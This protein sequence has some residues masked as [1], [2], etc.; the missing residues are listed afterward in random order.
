MPAPISVWFLVALAPVSPAVRG[1]DPSPDAVKRVLKAQARRIE[2]IERIAPAVVCVFDSDRVGGGSGVLIDDE[3]YGLTNFHVVMPMM[4]TR[5]G[6]GGLS[7]GHLYSLEVLGV[8]VTGDV[9]MFRLTKRTDDDSPMRD[10]FPF[11]PLGDSGEVRVG[12]SVIAM[13]NPFVLAEDFKPTVTTGIVTGIHRY[14][15]EGENLVYTDCIQT[16]AAIN[17]GNSGGPLFDDRGRVIGINGRISAEMHRYA[18]GRYSVGLGYAISIDQI[19]RFMPTLRAGLLGKHGTLLATVMDEVDG[20]IFNDLYE[21]APAW[22]TGIRLGYRLLRFGDVDIMSANQF[23]SLL[24][25]Y[26]EDWP[27]PITFESRSRTA[28]KVVRLE[29]VT[30]R[31]A[32]RYTVNEEANRRAAEVAVRA[33]RRAILPHRSRRAPPSPA[34]PPKS[35]SWQ[36]ERKHEADPLI[37]FRVHDDADGGVR[38]IELDGDGQQVRVVEYRNVKSLL[39]RFDQRNVTERVEALAHAA[40]YVL[41][42]KLLGTEAVWE[43]DGFRHVGSDALLT[44][45]ENGHVVRERRLEAVSLP[46]TEHVSLKVGFEL[47]THLPARLVVRDEPS[48]LEVEIELDDYLETDGMVWP[49]RMQVRSAKLS[50]EETISELRVEF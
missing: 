31:M 26:P 42:R 16:D 22:N 44:I 2:V 13:G 41:R 45:D 49:R 35:W 28:H 46:L 25:T 4:R 50:F 34:A 1:A 14:Q 7:D 19:K 17:P 12:D 15:G 21:D 29:G 37:T 33:F 36:A 30:P 23:L 9:A 10:R 8:D 40:M 27:V 43:E 39:A 24:G 5:R 47:D 6:L 38:R 20:V 3:G 18:R 48:E 11:A 32:Y